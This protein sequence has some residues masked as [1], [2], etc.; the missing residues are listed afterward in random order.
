VGLLSLLFTA[1]NLL[2]SMAA[3]AS[4]KQCH[5]TTQ[6]EAF[7]TGNFKRFAVIFCAICDRFKVGC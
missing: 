6:A 3:T 2:P 7:A 5:L 1:L 4:A